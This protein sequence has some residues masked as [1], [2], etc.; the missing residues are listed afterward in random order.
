M[1]SLDPCQ[2]ASADPAATRPVWRPRAAL[3]LLGAPALALVLQA[4]GGD[5]E[6]TP[7][8]V[9]SAANSLQSRAGSAASSLASQASS[10]VPSLASQA[11]SAGSSL[12][13]QGA[14]AG[15][16]LASQGAS[17]GSSL[18]SR[19][20]SAASSVS[21]A[22]ALP[23]PGASGAAVPSGA[24]DVQL[25]VDGQPLLSVAAAGGAGLSNLVGKSVEAKGVPVES[26]PS[27][28]GFWVG[29]GGNSRV[30]V[31]LAGGGESPVKVEK[32]DRVDFTGSLDQHGANFADRAGVSAKEGAD[33]L[34]QQAVHVQVQK[35]SVKVSP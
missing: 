26:V 11:A 2:R 21:S 12:A 35:D 16:S 28:E 10:A 25:N 24:G 22:N 27:D 15:S 31:Q 29:T 13:S 8:S 32:G 34:G 19:A 33:L 18:T 17:A 3:V 6:V 4:C 9:S 23:S 20:A 7:G 1:P 30:F 14:S 5:N